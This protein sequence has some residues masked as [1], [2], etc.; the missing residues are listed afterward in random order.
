MILISPEEP[1]ARF[2]KSLSLRLTLMPDGD[3]GVF[4]LNGSV[5]ARG[6]QIFV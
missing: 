1:D 5:N 4:A 3:Q 6:F 2:C